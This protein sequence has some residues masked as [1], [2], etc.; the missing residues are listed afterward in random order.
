MI[1]DNEE[2]FLYA[3]IKRLDFCTQWAVTELF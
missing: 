1:V 2:S 3:K